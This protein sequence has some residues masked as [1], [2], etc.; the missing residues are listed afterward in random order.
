MVW[1][2]VETDDGSVFGDPETRERFVNT[3]NKSGKEFRFIRYELLN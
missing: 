3:F 2:D 1:V